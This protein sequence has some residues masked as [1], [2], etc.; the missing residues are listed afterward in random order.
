MN[1]G[2]GVRAGMEKGRG[3]SCLNFDKRFEEVALDLRASIV[4]CTAGL[5]TMTITSEACKFW[6]TCSV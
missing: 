4:L 2:V 3:R 1:G 5:A 6:N